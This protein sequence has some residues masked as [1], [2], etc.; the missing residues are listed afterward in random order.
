MGVKEA[1]A[2]LQAEGEVENVELRVDECVALVVVESER[3]PVD[4]TLTEAVADDTR[5]L[6]TCEVPVVEAQALLQAE[7]EEEALEHCVG[8]EVPV[9]QKD[10]VCVVDDE[11]LGDASLLG[12]M[13][14]VAETQEVVLG[15]VEKVATCEVAAGVAEVVAYTLLQADSVAEEKEL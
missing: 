12:E 14:G 9:A 11:A 4:D 1:H 2:L 7:I 13:L 15:E 6:V 3:E 10:P 8:A 5:L